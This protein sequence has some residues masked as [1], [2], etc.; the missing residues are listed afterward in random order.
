MPDVVLP[1]AYSRIV[2]GRSQITTP[3]HR[4][5]VSD[6]EARRLVGKYG[7]IVIVTKVTSHEKAGT[8]FDPGAAGHEIVGRERSPFDHDGSGTAGGSLPANPTP[9]AMTP[10]ALVA[11]A[12][13]MAYFTFVAEARQTLGTKMPDSRRKEDILQALK[14]ATDD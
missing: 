2:D 12:G 10:A 13:D 7:A 6:R 5:T 3:G 8:S 1:V 4:I 11:A 9:D 14:E